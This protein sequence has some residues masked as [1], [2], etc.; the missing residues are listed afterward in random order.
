MARIRIPF[1]TI[2][3]VLRASRYRCFMCYAWLGDDR[4]KRG[5]IE[6][7]D[8]DRSNNSEDNLSFVCLGHYKG[9]DGAAPRTDQEIIR[10][11]YFR[12]QLY[13]N[14]VADP[15]YFR[16]SGALLDESGKLLDESGELLHE[17]G[18]LLYEIVVSDRE[19]DDCGI[20]LI[21]INDEIKRYLA[22]HPEKLHDL[23]PRQF[24]QLIASIIKDMGLD[25]ELTKS[26]RDGGVDI[27][28]YVR[29]QVASFLMIVECKKWGPDKP[30]GLDI[31]QRLY[32]VHHSKSANK[33][34]IITTSF[35]TAAAKEECRLYRGQMD[36]KDYTDLKSWLANYAPNRA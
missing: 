35:F 26:T 10:L 12:N 17:S 34:M 20:Q 28:A 8:H 23:S 33:S 14:V 31:V 7:L 36:L 11:K 27:Y 15:R 6:H 1:E 29:H 22:R 9:Y 2:Q 32:G 4:V 30:V 24:E 16:G 19:F 13:H 3:H 25:V 21:D 5:M 18:E